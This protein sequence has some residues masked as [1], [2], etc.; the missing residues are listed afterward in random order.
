MDKLDVKRL[1]NQAAVEAAKR[2]G[3]SLT[4]IRSVLYADIAA[5]YQTAVNHEGVAPGFLKAWISGW[6]NGYGN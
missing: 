2:S 5:A 6:R 1:G 3:V 4:S